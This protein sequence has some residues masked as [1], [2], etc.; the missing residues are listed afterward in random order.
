MQILFDDL[1]VFLEFW[2]I[3]SQK[4]LIFLL[5]P[6][7]SEL[8]VIVHVD[9][10]DNMQEA[11]KTYFL[12]LGNNEMVGNMHFD[13][14]LVEKL[15]NSC[16]NLKIFGIADRTVLYYFQI[17]RRSFEDLGLV[18]LHEFLNITYRLLGAQILDTKHIHLFQ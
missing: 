7:Q 11:I 6:Y 4:D 13:F 16:K 3:G 10:V 17:G 15:F 2:Y 8:I 14:V 18:F 12:D 1:C 5:I 9:F